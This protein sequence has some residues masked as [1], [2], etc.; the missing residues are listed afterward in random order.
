MVA[1]VIPEPHQPLAAHR[2]GTAVTSTEPASQLDSAMLVQYVDSQ[3]RLSW[4]LS[5]EAPITLGRDR[6]CAIQLRD[7][8][9]SRHHAC[10]VWV[11]DQYVI[12]DL[13]S[14]NGT[15]VNRELC[16]RPHSLIDGDEIQLGGVTLNF[17]DEE[18]TEPLV[19]TQPE[20]GL[21]V[22]HSSRSFSIDGVLAEEPLSPPQF[23][24]LTMLTDADGEIVSRE[25]IVETVWSDESRF[26]VSE[27]AIDA[28]I[29]RIRMR[30]EAFDPTHQYVVTVR[31]YGFRFVQKV[32]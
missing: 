6:S 16:S 17:L 4:T 12:E 21:N 1:N 2:N 22:K 13:G 23:R 30:I 14:T 15:V 32:R 19:S 27:Q 5:R 18:R 3:E 26:G 28:V 20:A 10:I 24:M 25:Q 8:Q 9:I 29:R 7:R 31:G 11:Q